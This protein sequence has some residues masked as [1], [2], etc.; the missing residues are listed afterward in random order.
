VQG[1]KLHLEGPGQERRSVRV[2][3]TE[4]R[5]PRA[6][7]EIPVRWAATSV[8]VDGEMSTMVGEEGNIAWQIDREGFRYRFEGSEM[9]WSLVVG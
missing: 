5:N 3:S 7:R 9:T 4:H 6:V 8:D 1:I 2:I